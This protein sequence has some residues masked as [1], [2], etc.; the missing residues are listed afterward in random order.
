MS[1]PKWKARETYCIKYNK[2]FKREVRAFNG[3]ELKDGRKFSYA[4][5][6]AKDSGWEEQKVFWICK[7]DGWHG[8]EWKYVIYPIPAHQA[9]QVWY[10]KYNYKSLIHIN[11]GFFVKPNFTILK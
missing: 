2:K 5:W 7:H 3:F 4:C 1:T 8:N 10:P 11:N 9:I 6:W